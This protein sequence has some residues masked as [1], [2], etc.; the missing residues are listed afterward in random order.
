MSKK[1]LWLV[2]PFL[3]KQ[4][5]DTKHKLEKLFKSKLPFCNIR[6]VFKTTKRISHLF[7]FKDKIPEQLRSHNVYQYTCAG[8]NSCYVGLSERHTFVRWCDHLG[9]SW[10]TNKPIVGLNTEVRDHVKTCNKIISIDEFKIITHEENVMNLKI[11]E[12]LLIKRD[13]PLL[14]KNVYSTPLYL[15]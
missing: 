7:S 4:S 12:S 8:C 13:K 15:F 9:I 1:Q 14:N 10:R 5:L 11:K 3:G 2:L 6:I